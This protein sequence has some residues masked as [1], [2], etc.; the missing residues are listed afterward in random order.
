MLNNIHLWLKDYFCQMPT[1]LMSRRP[2]VPV[3]I[4]FS[5]VDHFEPRNGG[6]SQV[7]ELE[8]TRR[9][10]AKYE[11]LVKK[12]K[13]HAGIPP[14]YSFFYPIDEY[15]RECVDRVADFCCKG[16]GEV[17][18]HLHH[19][20]DTEESLRQ[21]LFQAVE[22]FKSHGLLSTDQATGAVRYG[23]IHGNWSLCNSRPDGKWCGVNEELKVLRSTGCYADFTL[24][25][26]PSDT[27]TSKINSIYYAT[28]RSTP[29]AH[30]T[31]VDVAAGRKPSGDLMIVQG[32][33]M[34]NWKRGK[35][36]NSALLS[37]NPVTEDR[38]KL[39]VQ[40]GIH[41]KGRQDVIFIKVHNHGCREDHLTDRFF[42]N[43]D[44]MFT[45]LETKYNDG[46]KFKLHY[47]TAREMYNII[48]AIEGGAM[49][50]PVLYH[51]HVLSSNINKS[52]A[53]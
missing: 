9:F 42:E 20:G 29:K 21:K 41:V 32:A 18:I 16:Y 48:K 53:K 37:S 2:G 14:R 1:R 5:I 6:V 24:P 15:T 38:V 36:E 45:H 27:Q 12:H 19:Q 25:S 50:D 4:V 52:D 35:I 43:L 8:R 47:A 34:L 49:G 26:A 46:K 28:N 33:L 23:F 10:L 17:E 7:K 13:D 39:W 30:N 31:G 22:V 44:W 40:G 11:E 51:D 3:H